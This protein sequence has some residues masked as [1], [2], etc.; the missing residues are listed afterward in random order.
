MSNTD[1]QKFLGG[2]RTSPKKEGKNNTGAIP[3]RDSRWR[4]GGKTGNV[5]ERIE[6]LAS[7]NTFKQRW[8]GEEGEA[9]DGID[10]KGIKGRTAWPSL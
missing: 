1:Y 5:D 4:K 8:Y 6:P 10:T 7:V 9:A 2:D 3:R